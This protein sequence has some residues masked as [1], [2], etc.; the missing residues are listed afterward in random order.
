MLL[1]KENT[2]NGTYRYF[3]YKRDNSPKNLTSVYQGTQGQ[4]VKFHEIEIQLFHEVKF[5][6]M[7]SKL[8]FFMRLNFFCKIDQAIE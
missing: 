5:L 6:I 8:T 1:N 4:E 7:R 3:D 2:K